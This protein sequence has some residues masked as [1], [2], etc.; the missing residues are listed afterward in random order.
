M[1]TKNKKINIDTDK[2]IAI[3]PPCKIKLSPQVRRESIFD[4]LGHIVDYLNVCSDNELIEVGRY[5]GR[6]IEHHR[7][8]LTHPLSYPLTLKGVPHGE[9]VGA[10]LC[11]CI[12]KAFKPK[13]F[14]PKEELFNE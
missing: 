1:W 9:A 13:A 4:I 12:R 3:S 8:N 10:V 11:Y 2:P 6:L 14:K 5:A 7:T